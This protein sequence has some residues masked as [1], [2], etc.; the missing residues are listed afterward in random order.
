MTP[1]TIPLRNTMVRCSSK[2]HDLKITQEYFEEVIA[3]RKRH[4][5]R[6]NDRDFTL[7]DWLLLREYNINASTYTGRWCKALVSYISEGGRFGIALDHCVMS[8]ML[9][10]VGGGGYGR[11]NSID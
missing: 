5:I 4:E 1:D 10:E 6:K 8:L 2:T 3:G 9:M 11:H 7:G